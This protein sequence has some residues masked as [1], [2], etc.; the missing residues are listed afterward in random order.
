MTDYLPPQNI[1]AEKAVLGSV[2][3]RMESLASVCSFLTA[4]MFYKTAHNRIFAHMTE[5]YNEDLEIDIVT[6]SESLTKSK[7]LDQVGG[8]YYLTELE[9]TVPSSANIEDHARIVLEKHKLRKVMALGQYLISQSS[10]SLD[11]DELIDKAGNELIKISNQ[12]A[13]EEKTTSEILHETLDRIDKRQAGEIIGV[14]VPFERLAGMLGDLEGGE[15]ILIAARPSQGKTSMALQIAEDVAFN[16]KINVG[17]MSLE[18]TNEQLMIRILSQIAQ[19]PGGKIKFGCMDNSQYERF[20]KAT[21]TI[22]ENSDRIIMNDSVYSIWEIRS[23]AIRLKQK[24]NI[25][26]LIIDYLQLIDGKGE[27][28]N[29]IIQNISRSLKLVAKKLDIPVVA[30]S[31]LSRL[32]EG[33]EPSMNHLRESGA[34]EQDADKIIFPY[35]PDYKDG[36]TDAMFI[37]GKN[38]DGAVGKI[39]DVTFQ[40][41]IVSFVNG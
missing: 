23:R 37:I 1:E 17:I 13:N 35:R 11:P 38:R 16:Q 34:L 6:L 30:L 40:K 22:Y 26:I 29:V 18:T 31:Q 12:T 10:E 32:A 24:H 2:L 21:Q 9:E 3:K 8:M 39:E 14:R 7:L 19:V 33:I 36:G 5:M 28:R 41:E 20:N 25:G 4:G 15:F 27:N